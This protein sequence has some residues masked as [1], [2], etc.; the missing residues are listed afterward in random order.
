MSSL[1]YCIRTILL[2]PDDLA[3]VRKHVEMAGNEE[4][5]VRAFLAELQGE[6]EGLRQQLAAQGFDAVE[7]KAAP[8]KSAPRA[9]E[10]TSPSSDQ[11]ED[12]GEKIHGARKDMVTEYVKTLG[13]EANVAVEPLSKTFPP[14]N[15]AKLVESGV[16]KRALAYVALFRNE[17]PSRPKLPGRARNW[18]EKVKLLRGFAHNLLSDET[19]LP[20]LEEKLAGEYASLRSLVNMARVMEGM[21]PEMFPFAAQW[22]VAGSQ[23]S[24]LN[25]ERFSPAKFLYILNDHRNRW[26]NVHGEKVDDVLDPARALIKESYD[27]ENASGNGRRTPLSL[28]NDRK[29]Q[30]VWIGF[31]GLGNTVIRLKTGFADVKAA[32]LYI[33]EHADD[34]QKQ[35]DEMREGPVLRRAANMPRVGAQRRDG[36]VTPQIFSETF[37]FRGVQFGNYVE[38]D[39]RQSDLN[40]SFDAL[41]DLADVLDIPPRALS[42]NGRLGLAFGAR[43]HGGR[44]AAAAH[45]EP[46]QVV[47]NLTKHG[48]PGSL[49]H[50][51]LHALDNY[52]GKQSDGGYVSEGR[53]PGDVREAVFAAWKGIEAVLKTGDFAKRSL[54]LDKARSKPYFSTTIEKAARSFERYVVDR[55][56]AKGES[57]DYLA[58][59]NK[60]GGAYPTDSEMSGQGIR[61]AWD[62]LFNTIETVKDEATGRMVMGMA[63]VAPPFYSAL[64][65]TVTGLKMAKAPASQWI[66]TLKNQPGVKQEEM[67]WLGVA[68]WLNAQPGPVTKEALAD[69]INSNQVQVQEVL[70]GGLLPGQEESLTAEYQRYLEEQGLPSMSADELALE[71]GVTPEQRRW[72]QDFSRRWDETFSSAGAPGTKFA[73]WQLPGGENYREMLLTL[74][75]PP[76]MSVDTT[77][78][79]VV[80]TPGN[81]A[82]NFAVMNAQDEVVRYWED[83]LSDEDMIEQTAE[84]F[85]KASRPANWFKSGHWSEPNVLAHVRFN[86]RE[87]DGKR[88]LFIEE[89]QSDWHQQ[90]RKKG[91]TPISFKDAAEKFRAS[92]IALDIFYG[93]GTG[94][95]YRPTTIKLRKWKSEEG[96]DPSSLSPE[97]AKVFEQTQAR[98][99]FE[100]LPAFNRNSVPD[101]PFKTTWP[102]LALKRMIR[103]AAENGFD[104]IAW[105]PGDVQAERYNLSRVLDGV[106]WTTRPQV[107]KY[108]TAAVKG[109]G[110]GSV[111]TNVNGK[112]VIAKGSLDSFE[113]KNLDEVFGKDLAEK[114]M[115]EETGELEGEGLR[116]GGQGMKAFYDKMLVDAANKLGKKFGAK[117][118]QTKIEVDQRTQSVVDIARSLNI[119]GTGVGEAGFEWTATVWWRGLTQEQKTAE[120]KAYQKRTADQV[121]KP[122]HTLPIT[123]DMRRTALNGVPLF[124][125]KRP[126]APAFTDEQFATVKSKMEKLAQQ[127]LKRRIDVSLIKTMPRDIA[128]EFLA[129]YDANSRSIMISMKAAYD[130]AAAVG[131]ESLHALRDAGV[132]N[133]A[134]W[135]SLRAQANKLGYRAMV[136]KQYGDLYRDLYGKEWGLSEA[137]VED[138]IDEEAVAYMMGD[139]TD[140]KEKMT[141]FAQ[142]VIDRLMEWARAV[143]SALKDEGIT[144]EQVMADIY[145]GKMA[146]RLASPQGQVMQPGLAV[147]ASAQSRRDA[148]NELPFKRLL[149]T[150][151]Q[152]FGYKIVDTGLPF[153]YTDQWGKFWSFGT[154]II[155]KA[156]PGDKIGKWMDSGWKASPE[157]RAYIKEH[158]TAPWAHRVWFGHDP[159]ANLPAFI[160]K[161]GVSALPEW[162]VQLFK[163][164][165][166]KAGIPLPGT[167]WLVQSG[168]VGDRFATAWLSMNI[169]EALSGGLSILGTY[170]LMKQVKNGEPVHKGWAVAG[171]LFKLV[172]G[173]LSANPVVLL[174]AAADAAILVKATAGGVRDGLQQMERG[175]KG[176][177]PMAGSDNTPRIMGMATPDGSMGGGGAVPPKAVAID[178]AAQDELDDLAGN[179]RLSRLNAPDDIKEMLKDV[180]NKAEGFMSER[181]GIVSN[182]QTAALAAELGMTAEEL[183]QRDTGT[184]FNA[185]QIF[186]ARVMLL[187]SAER[188]KK[189]AREARTSNSLSTLAE[190]QKA[191]TRHRAIQE[192]V[193]GMTA[194]AGRALQQFNMIAAKDSLR[195]MDM[196]LNGVRDKKASR[197]AKLGGPNE[198]ARELADM[199]SDMDDPAKL[200]KFIAD[201]QKATVWDMIR[202]AWIN[203]LLSGPRTHAANIL[204]NTLTAL[205]QVPE[206]F[207]AEQIGRL[208]GGDKVQS[209][210][211]A[212]RL[213]GLIEGTKEGIAVGAKHIRHGEA[214]DAISKAEL[215]ERKAIPGKVGNIIR[216]PSRILEAEDQVFKAINYRAEINALALRQAMKEGHRGA[217]LTRRVAEL[218]ANPTHKMQHAAHQAA[219]YQTYQNKL[220]VRGQWVMNLREAVPLGWLIMPFIRTPANILKYAAERTPL[221]LLMKPVRENLSG[222]NGTVARDVQLARIALGSA[223]MVAVVGMAIAGHL[224]G[225]PPDDPEEERILRATGWQPY[226]LRIGDTYYSYQRMDP[227]ALV[228]GLAADTVMLSKHL[229]EADLQKTAHMLVMAVANNVKE[230]TWISGLV[231]FAEAFFSGDAWKLDAWGRRLGSSV[232]PAF[233]AQYA[234]SQ[235]PYIREAKTLTDAIKARVPGWSETLLARRDVF[236]EKMMREGA[237]GPDIASPFF[238]S[239]VKDNPVAREMLEIGYYPSM[240][241]RKLAGHELTAQQ[242]DRYVELS[243]KTATTVLR[244]AIAKPSWK[245]MSRDDKEETIRKEFSEAR[246]MARA[247]LKREWPELRKK[248]SEE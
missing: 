70:K 213:V 53:R 37:G 17:I 167:Q 133:A 29:A 127:I 214:L 31:K 61:E 209:G 157:L 81:F 141:T 6:L 220:G 27:R 191:V 161:F 92:G 235:D 123:P 195:A 138:K 246:K 205:W 182:E 193:A 73:Q 242:Y 28:Y 176:R 221:G 8:Q 34:L 120:I 169:G 192:Q 52:F 196:L 248:A 65:R 71:D 237:L 107:G 212:A 1:A 100:D 84:D 208:H 137:G 181:R 43:G 15:Y 36:D 178:Q 94:A 180:A 165:L 225:G 151:A 38:G 210:E 119:P 49:A 67:D 229:G 211:A 238:V 234:Q 77:G 132:I 102:E 239:E 66:A 164:S 145:R 175:K 201:M 143:V 32:R 244:A 74:P 83:A 19:Y 189:L 236:G 202:E 58:N 121:G 9:R 23:V 2:D 159:L 230:K 203:G 105:T 150:V 226:S 72:L 155:D 188:L 87:V 30:T 68:D 130:L 88:V 64:A 177:M 171:I 148:R 144:A 228:V 69:F 166:T 51:W 78:W 117:V 217:S 54:E 20:K 194:E 140:A 104:S 47:I 128:D 222:A 26:T 13:E 75:T 204:S 146:D 216:M 3:L 95:N 173:T 33:Q 187:K 59:I 199:I 115:N 219:L 183:M 91:Y 131:H 122:V 243:G 231:T 21:D 57:N 158:M 86:E 197:G 113:G 240:P 79:K 50:E 109:S 247:K 76:D 233:V 45:Y 129:F 96:V 25:G 103:W 118:G 136:E 125:A 46:G 24:M 111:M 56:E 184:A 163:D 172:G 85:A 41:M 10:R 245:R 12:F 185:Q 16:S 5:G 101:A 14:P 227:M 114:I 116:I 18:A 99:R 186:A 142:K 190:F 106:N 124:T 93:G 168:L 97:L 40:E 207:V 139:Y 232:V 98:A 62:N 200:G 48:G 22:N 152:G 89:V 198:E 126:S 112:I 90:G 4:A 39:R 153:G 63:G 42:L 174:S 82:G 55:M 35:I 80:E 135:E 215:I 224:T 44:N 160:D 154:Q 108:I 147:A 223:V 206:T 156:I 170:R 110:F 149:D 179:I 134:E 162:G 241:G 7:Q 60:D 218:R 11:I